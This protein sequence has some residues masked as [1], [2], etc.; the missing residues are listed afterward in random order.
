MSNFCNPN[1]DDYPEAARKHLDDAQVLLSGSRFDG[2][3]YHAGYVVECVLK[4]LLQQESEVVR[5]HN[6]CDLSRR[7]NAL[8]LGG[9]PDIAKYIPDPLPSLRY[10]VP[11]A[12]WQE[13][14]RYRAEGDLN[15]LTAQEWVH[16]A[17]RVY[18]H[19]IRQMQNDGVIVR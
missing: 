19:I 5:E 8:A 12:G 10:V 6:L 2:A 3:G 16:E 4:T 15:Q 18:D 9:S 11:P 1:G 14:M 13:T 17:E 7:V